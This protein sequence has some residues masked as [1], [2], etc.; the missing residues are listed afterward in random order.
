MFMRLWYK[1]KYN[2]KPNSRYKYILLIMP[3]MLEW[4]LLPFDSKINI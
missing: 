2:I 1:R 3:L 4:E